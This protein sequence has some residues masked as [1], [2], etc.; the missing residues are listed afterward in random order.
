MKEKKKKLDELGIEPKASRMRSGRSTPELHAP[1]LIWP[2]PKPTYVAFGMAQ[3]NYFE[4][5]VT[6]ERPNKAPTSYRQ[7]SRLRVRDT[8]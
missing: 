1:V 3:S 4:T 7:K 8:E 6:S 2:W 5:P